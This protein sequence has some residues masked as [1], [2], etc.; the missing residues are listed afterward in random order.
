MSENEVLVYV[1]VCTQVE[2]SIIM[3]PYICMYMGLM[4]TQLQED[5]AISGL[6][7][8]GNDSTVRHNG[9]CISTHLPID[10]ISNRLV[11]QSVCSLVNH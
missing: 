10:Y 2:S 4:C 9:V 1:H 7:V 11:F 5:N 8:S 3:L 6:N